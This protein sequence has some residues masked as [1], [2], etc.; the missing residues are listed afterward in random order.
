MSVLS[1]IQN[2]GELGNNVESVPKRSLWIIYKKRKMPYSFL[3][4]A[5][6]ITKKKRR[7]QIYLRFITSAISDPVQRTNFIQTNYLPTKRYGETAISSFTV[8]PELTL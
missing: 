2:S 7:I 4:K 3:L 1:G 8:I 6:R 5:A